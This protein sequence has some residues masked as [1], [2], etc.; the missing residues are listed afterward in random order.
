V[1]AGNSAQVAAGL[2]AE[3]DA[4]GLTASQRHGSAYAVLVNSL[5]GQTV[6]AQYRGRAFGMAVTGVMAL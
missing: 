4:A 3:A 1:L 2:T 5:F 6:P